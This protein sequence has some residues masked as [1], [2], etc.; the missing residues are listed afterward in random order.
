LRGCD[1][2]RERVGME[3]VE[4]SGDEREEEMREEGWERKRDD[5][6][7]WSQLTHY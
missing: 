3:S 1:E 6:I 2:R 4:G 5:V 7:V